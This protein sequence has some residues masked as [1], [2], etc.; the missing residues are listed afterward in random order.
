MKLSLLP[1][2]VL[3]V[4]ALCG[5]CAHHMAPPADASARVT[6]KNGTPFTHNGECGGQGGVDHQAT[7][8]KTQSLR[9]T[10]VSGAGAAHQPGEVWATPAAKTYYCHGDREYGQAKEG[11]YMSESEAMAKGL[12]AAGGKR[13][14]S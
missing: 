11:K 5:G 8:E 7:R 3:C 4:A 6:C 9:D 2:S 10:Q 14:T 13:C 1:P 12:H